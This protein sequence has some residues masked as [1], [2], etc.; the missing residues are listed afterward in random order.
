LSHP[1]AKA[2]ASGLLFFGLPSRI[3]AQTALTNN[4]GL[5]SIPC[6]NQGVD[7]LTQ[8]IQFPDTEAECFIEGPTERVTEFLD[9]LDASSICR[10]EFSYPSNC[11]EKDIN[12]FTHQ[13]ELIPW[14]SGRYTPPMWL[15]CQ[16]DAVASSQ[17]IKSVAEDIQE[18]YKDAD[19]KATMII[20]FGFI[21]PMA[22]CG[23][24]AILGAVGALPC[25]RN[26]PEET[27][28]VELSNVANYR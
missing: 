20:S 21:L 10:D 18:D 27:N 24:L 7:T 9:D 8:R 5:R 6:R 25:Q 28:Q 12:T 26:K 1:L 4:E 23:A 3:A 22:T 2:I 16:E 15:A 13:E 17:C 11:T 19:M 14:V